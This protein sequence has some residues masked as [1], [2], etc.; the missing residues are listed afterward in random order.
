MNEE[1]GYRLEE[2]EKDV[3][4]SHLKVTKRFLCEVLLT[5]HVLK[6]YLI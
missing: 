5:K 3:I 6:M 1:D 4:F 2:K